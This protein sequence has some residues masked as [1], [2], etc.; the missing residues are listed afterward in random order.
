MTPIPVTSDAA[1]PRLRA[2][3]R[4][5]AAAARPA[6][7]FGAFLLAV[8]VIGAVAAPWLGPHD[9]L[10]QDIVNRLTSPDSTY[11]LGTDEFGRDVLSRL[12]WGGRITLSV[13]VLSIVGAALLGGG[14]GMIAGY[15]GGRTDLIVMRAMDVLQSFPSLILGLIIVALLGASLTNLILAIALTAVAPFARIARAPVLSLKERPFIEAGRALGFSRS[16]ILLVHI[17]PNIRGEL[18]VM[19][20]LWMAAAARTEAA[21]AF[22]GLGIPPPFPTW[23]G[24]IRDGLEHLTD[25]PWLSVAPGLAIFM[26]ILGLNM[27][28]DSLRDALDARGQAP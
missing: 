24:M 21:L 23:G 16:R 20:S 13:S 1:R 11:L 4:V 26:L 9:P 28:G 17:L 22:I 5:A 7:V 25:A 6:A 14:I 15:A 18:L 12:L 3:S 27:L 8:I 19:A 2:M 10:E